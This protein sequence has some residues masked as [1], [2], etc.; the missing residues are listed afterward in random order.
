MKFIDFLHIQGFSDVHVY[1]NMCKHFVCELENRKRG[2]IDINILYKIHVQVCDKNILIYIY[3]WGEAPL[4]PLHTCVDPGGGGG[5]G[6]GQ[7]VLM[8]NHKNIGFLSNTGQD[9]L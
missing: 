4:I 5:G 3:C 2:Y 9:L 1:S 8:K 7:G 6:G